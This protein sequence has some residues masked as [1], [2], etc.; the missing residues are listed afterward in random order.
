MVTRNEITITNTTRLPS[1]RGI[2]AEYRGI[3]LVNVYAPSR[4]PKQQERELFYNNKLP[5]LLR[6]SSSNMIVGGDFNCALNDTHSIGQLNYSKA[7]DGLVR[8]F[9]LQDIWRADSLRIVFTHYSPMGTSR[10]DRIYTTKGLSNKK[11]CVETVAA[12]FTDH[13]S[14]VKL[15]S[16]D[17]PIVRPGKGFWKMNTSI[18]SDEAFQ[19]KLRQKWPVW[20]QQTRFYTD[21]PTWWGR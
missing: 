2:A 1:G 12:A 7:L 8:G 13:L 17:V 19:E 9:E 20:R 14:V 4:T 16:V 11:I 6:A 15:L 5:Y 21:W 18:L 10:I 3:W